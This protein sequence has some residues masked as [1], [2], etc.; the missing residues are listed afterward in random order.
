M[1]KV[2]LI[3]AN[4]DMGLYKFRKE[5]IQRLVEENIKVYIS[6]PKGPYVPMLKDLGCEYIDT[7]IKRRQ[8]NPITDIKLLVKYV[9]IIKKVHPDV[10]LTYTIKPNIYGGLACRITKTPYIA[11]VTGLGTAIENVGLLQKITLKLYKI[12]LKKS[13]VVFFQNESNKLFF[14][15]NN[16]IKTKTRL[17]PGSGVN[18]NKYNFAEYPSQSEKIKLLFIG[19]IMK[20][21]GINELL[22]SAKRIKQK[23]PG[24]E[25]DIIGSSKEENYAPLLEKLKTNNIIN[26][27][28]RQDDVYSFIKNSH[29]I[30]NPSH[31]EGMSNVLLE[32]ASTGR[33]ILASDIPGCRETFDEGVSGL[34]FEVKN[35]DS[36]VETIIKFIELPYE[37]KKKMGL[38]GRRK[39]E[40]EFDRN[41]VIKAYINEIDCIINK[42]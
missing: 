42:N 13:A 18:I 39:M 35:V 27:H 14:V 26:Y 12:G 31:H 23:Y 24:V 34:G 16:I 22:E 9:E 10:V 36:L 4:S 7:P 11:N 6:L 3:L 15:K 19:R 17:I 33:P 40:K 41:I 30:I 38:A 8:K 20:A 28:G 29:A 21:K 1:K 2:I 32:S 25:F 37:E 5:L